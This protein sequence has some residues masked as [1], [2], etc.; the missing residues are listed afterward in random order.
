MNK[1]TAY[2]VLSVRDIETL[3][4]AAV[5]SA[6]AAGDNKSH[7][8]LLRDIGLTNDRGCDELQISSHDITTRAEAVQAKVEDL[9]VFRASR[10]A[11]DMAQ[12]VRDHLGMK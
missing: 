11:S 12:S 2:L 8:I 7:C 1:N 4:A 3:L 10:N 6:E 5:A 9:E